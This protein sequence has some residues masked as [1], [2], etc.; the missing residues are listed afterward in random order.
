VSRPAICTQAQVR[1]NIRAAKKEGL[2]V[3]EIKPDGTLL[4]QADD[5][6]A[7]PPR[8]EQTV[9]DGWDTRA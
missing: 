1:R 8:P 5:D 6:L 7:L 9:T 4:L 2:R 3:A